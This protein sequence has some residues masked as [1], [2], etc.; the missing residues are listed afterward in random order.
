MPT[1]RAWEH[2]IEPWFIRNGLPYFVPSER[3]RAKDALRPRRAL[4]LLALVVLAAV[5]A[6][7]ALTWLT[8]EASAAP[9]T[10]TTV[11]LLAAAAYAVTALRARPILGWALRRTRSSLRQLLPM[12]TRALPLLLLFVTFLFINAEVWQL[13]AELDGPVMWL[14]V[15][16]FAVI[17]VGFLLVRLPE[18]VDKVD[19]FIDL[20]LVRRATR[21]TP[22]EQPVA[23]LLDARG[24]ELPLD[25]YGDVPGYERW[26][27]I[28][29]LLVTQVAQVL[30]LSLAV[31]GFFLVFG[32]IV[33]EAGVQEAWTAQDRVHHLPYLDNL[34][35]ELVQVSV[36]LASFSGL[37][38]TVAVMTDETYRVQFFSEVLTELE[39]AVGVRAGY[40]ALRGAAEP[41]TVDDG[42][43]PAT[44]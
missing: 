29:V 44:D 42:A 24:E 40:L 36:F 20:D 26:N 21:R 37:Y 39:R 27:L 14:T 12:V 7:A 11:G 5:A 33:M 16:L 19:D 31:L 34:S 17:A 13:S 41:A 23:E 3:A 38:F 30:L 2:E 43:T 25:E 22:I 32:G 6:S 35:V 15:L 4:P 28:L 18:E 1:R 9:A 10:L 8:E